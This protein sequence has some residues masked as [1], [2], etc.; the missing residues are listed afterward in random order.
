MHRYEK[1]SLAETVDLSITNA[2][3][4][5][6]EAD[7]VAEF[8]TQKECPYVTLE[9]TMQQ[10]RTLD[11]LRASAGIEFAHEAKA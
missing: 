10:M 3:L 7:A 4:Y 9:D 8:F 1:Y 5:A 11:R 2:E 6:A